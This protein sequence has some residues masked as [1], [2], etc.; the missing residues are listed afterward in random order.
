MKYI[1]TFFLSSFNSLIK[2]DISFIMWPEYVSN[3]SSCCPA[4]SFISLSI[5]TN[6]NDE[7]NLRIKSG[8][9]NIK[10]RKYLVKT[11]K[12]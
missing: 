6:A 10:E 7:E 12:A 3:I 8:K 4:I 2:S 1:Q 5:L 11:N 9:Q